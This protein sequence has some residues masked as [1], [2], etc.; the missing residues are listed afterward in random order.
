MNSLSNN[1]ESKLL[2]KKKKYCAIHLDESTNIVT[3]AILFV[4]TYTTGVAIFS[5]IN[6]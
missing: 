2:N 3:S 4:K 1:V 6:D 5:M